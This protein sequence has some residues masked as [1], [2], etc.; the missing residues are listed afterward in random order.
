[1]A[2]SVKLSPDSKGIEG[3]EIL[4][5]GKSLATTDATGKFLLEKMTVGH[6]TVGV[7]KNGYA[8]DQI[9]VQLVPSKPELQ[10]IFVS[11]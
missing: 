9:K 5:N 7:R 11:K 10:T 8:F 3:A 1:M 2:G 4:V 6:Y